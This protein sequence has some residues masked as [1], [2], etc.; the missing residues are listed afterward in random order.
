M[1]Q[2]MSQA[3]AH[4]IVRVVI[5][6][7]F[8]SG[9]SSIVPFYRRAAILGGMRDFLTFKLPELLAVLLAVG[10]LVARDRR[11]RRRPPT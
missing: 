5:G 10:I 3:T 11:R 4:M 9:L 2:T 8:N 6:S 1:T 7:S